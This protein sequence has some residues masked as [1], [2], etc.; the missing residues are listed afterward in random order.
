[1]RG[2]H[3]FRVV[4]TGPTTYDFLDELRHPKWTEKIVQTFGVEMLGM[5]DSVVRKELDGDIYWLS[6]LIICPARRPGELFGGSGGLGEA[7]SDH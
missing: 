7:V 6:W 4:R 2:I 3:D 1:M 5:A